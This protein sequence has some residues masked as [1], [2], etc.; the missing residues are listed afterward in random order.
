MRYYINNCKADIV[1]RPRFSVSKDR[2]PVGYI[3]SKK[4]M[5]EY[6]NV[7]K[8]HWDFLVK[9]LVKEVAL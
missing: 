2:L 7:K 9:T 3:R 8:H 5:W 1:K 4:K 6:L